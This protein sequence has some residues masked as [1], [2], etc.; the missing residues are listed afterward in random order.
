MKHN[1][2]THTFRCHHAGG[3]EREYI[4]KAI[5]RSLETLGFSDHCPYSFPNGYVSGFRMEP[6]KTEGY[7]RTLGE[8]REEYEGK[9]E[10]PIGFEVE[11]Y[12]ELFDSLLDHLYQSAVTLPSG[13]VVRAQYIIMGQHFTHNE[14]D[15]RAYSGGLTGD[16]HVLADYVESVLKGLET[17]RFTYVAHP[18][19]VNYQGP[20]AIYEKHM[21]EICRYAKAH[22]IP[23][24]INLLG[25]NTGRNYP[26]PL[27][28]ELVRETGNT[29]VLGCDAHQVDQVANPAHIAAGL[30]FA[31]LAGVEVTDGVK[32][33]N[34]F[35]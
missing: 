21:L 5:E 15:I 11:Y 3:T 10:I 26:N 9:L 29:V 13:Q 16:E 8:L 32:L 4:E 33:R 34:P 25:L 19:I 23:L 6:D 30:E 17:G 12:P 31:R 20:D 7:Y 14:Y 18:D 2:H 35:G 28:W 27:F 24:E 1:Y 22:E